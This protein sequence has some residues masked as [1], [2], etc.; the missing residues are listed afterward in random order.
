MQVPNLLIHKYW[1]S[2]YSV[3]EANPQRLNF[4]LED[5]GDGDAVEIG[6]VYSMWDGSVSALKRDI[7]NQAT[8]VCIPNPRKILLDLEF[9]KA[10]AERGRVTILYRDYVY[11]PCTK[12]WTNSPEVMPPFN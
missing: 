5:S 6:V 10:L 1:G 12:K 3:L 8:V 11:D 4:L 7:G 9:L 2:L